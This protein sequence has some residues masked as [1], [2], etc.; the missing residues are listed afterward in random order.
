MF[1]SKLVSPGIVDTRGKGY[2]RE[3][4]GNS[5]NSVLSLF[6]LEALTLDEALSNKSSRKILLLFLRGG[7]WYFE[8]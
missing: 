4:K 6:S 8:H 3:K 2:G 5:D 7:G 1:L